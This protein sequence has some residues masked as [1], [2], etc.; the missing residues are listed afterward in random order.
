[1]FNTRDIRIG[2]APE[3][4]LLTVIFKFENF[5]TL[6]LKSKTQRAHPESRLKNSPPLYPEC[7]RCNSVQALVKDNRGN[8]W[9]FIRTC[10]QAYPFSQL[11][12]SL[13]GSLHWP[14]IF[15]VAKPFQ[16]LLFP[17]IVHLSSCPVTN[18]CCLHVRSA[19]H[20]SSGAFNYSTS[21][22]T[23]A[24]LSFLWTKN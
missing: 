14:L 8:A 17:S 5:K 21:K 6:H 22:A 18:H 10:F 2:R 3:I 11:S 19:S 1:M 4:S 9:L 16:K 12:M 24:I 15:T 23:Q 13:Q 7:I 20:L